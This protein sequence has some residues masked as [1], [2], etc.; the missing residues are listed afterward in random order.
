MTPFFASIVLQLPAYLARQDC[1]GN[2]R[3]QAMRRHMA[4][5][6]TGDG[7]ECNRQWHRMLL[8]AASYAMDDGIACHC[9]RHKAA[10]PDVHT[11]KPAQA[12][13]TCPAQA[14]VRIMPSQS[15]GLTSTRLMSNISVEL[16]GTLPEALAP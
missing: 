1:A 15:P 14:D 6:A 16:A 9:L 8:P 12:N 5:Y 4:S 13:V 11:K 3:R 7:I 2:C 10:R